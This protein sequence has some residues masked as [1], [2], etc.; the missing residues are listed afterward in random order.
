MERPL[1]GQCL[2]PGLAN[3]GGKYF[4]FP[5]ILGSTGFCF[6]SLKSRHA[7]GSPSRPSKI[8]HW[9][10]DQLQWLGSNCLC[11]LSVGCLDNF[12][13]VRCFFGYG[14]IG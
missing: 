3:F 14:S 13:K 2:C 7:L 5:A 8:I 12:P 10:Q 4:L 9:Y 6:Y 1:S 11:V